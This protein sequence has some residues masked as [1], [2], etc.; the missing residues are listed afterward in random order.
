MPLDGK[1]PRFYPCGN[2][3][4]GEDV[5][6]DLPLEQQQSHRSGHPIKM[7]RYSRLRRATRGNLAEMFQSLSSDSSKWGSDSHHYSTAERRGFRQLCVA[8]SK[9]LRIESTQAEGLQR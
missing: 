2:R 1:L 4:C 3:V 7:A 8:M 5:D 6:C 9:T